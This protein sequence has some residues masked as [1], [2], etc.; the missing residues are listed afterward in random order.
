MHKN[1]VDSGMFTTNLNWWSPDFHQQYPQSHFGNTKNSA[2]VEIRPIFQG[3]TESICSPSHQIPNPSSSCKPQPARPRPLLLDGS[4]RLPLGILARSRFAGLAG[5][6]RD[7][8]KKTA[9]R[10]AKLLEGHLEGHPGKIAKRDALLIWFWW[11][12]DFFGIILS[13]MEIH[14]RKTPYKKKNTFWD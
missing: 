1:P 7:R 3:K 12:G 2:K 13:T 9:T 4:E 10:H 8:K 11:F 14:E 5:I 6:L